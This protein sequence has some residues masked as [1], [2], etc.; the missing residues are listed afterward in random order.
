MRNYL[1]NGELGI[2]RGGRLNTPPELASQFQ[3]LITLDRIHDR[4]SNPFPKDDYDENEDDVLGPLEEMPADFVI[5][6]SFH[7]PPDSFDL[8]K[9]YIN[10][11]AERDIDPSEQDALEVWDD[12]SVQDVGLNVQDNTLAVMP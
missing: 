5:P 12:L 8:A 2:T 7:L 6:N 11:Q 3:C 4:F 10:H 9:H 1:N